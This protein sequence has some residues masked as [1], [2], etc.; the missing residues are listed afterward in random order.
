MNLQNQSFDQQVIGAGGARLGVGAAGHLGPRGLADTALLPEH[1][2]GIRL[3]V[4][5]LTVTMERAG[6]T[7]TRHASKDQFEYQPYVCRFKCKAGSVDTRKDNRKIYLR[8]DID[9]SL[10]SGR[11]EIGDSGGEK[12]APS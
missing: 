1:R 4:T 11:Y 8:V 12:S 6:S 10:M 3:K 7:H 9:D 2:S 5:R